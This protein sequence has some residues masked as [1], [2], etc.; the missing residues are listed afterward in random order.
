MRVPRRWV[1]ALGLVAAASAGSLLEPAW[2][3]DAAAG[4]AVARASCQACHGED[5]RAILVGAANLSGQQKEY[6]VQQLRAFRS[7]S[8][9][10]E[11]MSIIAKPL[12][13]ADIENVSDWYASIKVT[14]DAPK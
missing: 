6:L 12:T 10:N 2:A 4:R 13:D 8:R 3:G 1:S 14:I 5:G 7:G 9:R 11:Q